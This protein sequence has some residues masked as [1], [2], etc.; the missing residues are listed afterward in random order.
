MK[1]HC[2]LALVALGLLPRGVVID[3]K[4]IEAPPDGY[5]HDRFA[6][7]VG[8]DDV[9]KTFKAYVT[10]M[11]GADDDDGD[12]VADK[13]GIPHW[14]SYELR[15]F[16]GDLPKSP[17]RPSTW[18][19]DTD[20]YDPDG[21]DGI[22]PHDDSYRNSG[23]NRGH[24]CMKHHAWRLGENADWNTHTF[25]NCVPQKGKFNQ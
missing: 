23:Y 8:V 20:H 19:T 18:I 22:A 24:L 7:A 3:Y 11:D 21:D 15:R 10:C 25:L 17:K 12:G 6:P 16:P 9:E 13:W 2:S 5:D 4:E 14:V 1:L